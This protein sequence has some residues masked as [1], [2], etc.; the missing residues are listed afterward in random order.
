[1]HKEESK[2]FKSPLLPQKFHVLKDKWHLF[3]LHI[4]KT[5]EQE[6]Y[7]CCCCCWFISVLVPQFLQLHNV[8]FVD[9]G[10]LWWNLN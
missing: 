7:F 9:N 10:D 2:T 8:T 5:I 4:Q 3:I 6:A 1:M